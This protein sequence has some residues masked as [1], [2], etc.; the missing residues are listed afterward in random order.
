MRRVRFDKI[1]S[2]KGLKRRVNMC[3]GKYYF[4]HT[5]AARMGIIPFNVNNG[6]GTYD[7]SIIIIIM[8]TQFSVIIIVVIR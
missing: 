1:D 5:R 8:F 6:L 4:R 2:G 3:L 7:I